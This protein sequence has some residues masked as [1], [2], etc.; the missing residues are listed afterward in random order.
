MEEELKTYLA[1]ME[2]RLEGKIDASEQRLEGKIDASE[3]RLKVYVNQRVE[4]TE[5][6]LLTEFSTWSNGNQTRM[7]QVVSLQKTLLSLEQGH[8]E[9]MASLEG[10]MLNLEKRIWTKS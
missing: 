4:K 9:R 10:R 1:G 5:T 2:A 7:G 8:M 3:E 6:A